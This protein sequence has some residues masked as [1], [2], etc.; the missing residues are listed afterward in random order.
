VSPQNIQN[1]FGIGRDKVSGI[2][3][4][5]IEVNLLEVVR[6]K[7]ENGR[8]G[9]S[10]YIV[11]N[12]DDFISEDYEEGKSDVTIYGFPVTGKPTYGFPVTGKHT[13]TKERVTKKRINKKNRDK[14][15]SIM[16]KPVDNFSVVHDKKP[17]EAK[18]SSVCFKNSFKKLELIPENFEP[19]DDS[20]AFLRKTAERVKMPANDLLSKFILVMSKYK[21]R[22]D[23]WQNKFC[24]FL[25]N[26]RIKRTFEDIS[27]KLRRYD[28]GP[29]HY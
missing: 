27:G 18:F 5:L 10:F 11:K 24:T 14:Y 3:R 8:F 16:E 21:A 7:D 1:H 25:D 23:N 19:D 17:M 22:S 13:T 6:Q 9:A 26:E 2:L 20:Q 28:G 29:L 12:G 4:Y 15:A